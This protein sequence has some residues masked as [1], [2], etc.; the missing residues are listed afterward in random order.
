VEVWS[1]EEYA[2]VIAL[3][4]NRIIPEAI[5]DTRERIAREYPKL[6]V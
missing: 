4:V 3:M 2:I 6:C 5:D 1:F